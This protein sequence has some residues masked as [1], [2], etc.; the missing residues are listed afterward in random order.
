MAS[1]CRTG[2]LSLLA[3]EKK[4]ALSYFPKYR[5]L[6]YPICCLGMRNTGHEGAITSRPG[7]PKFELSPPERAV[8][9]RRLP[10]RLL[11]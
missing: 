3:V 7:L 11:S 9:G 10:N 8:V 6:L 5:G 2:T 4:R 1:Q